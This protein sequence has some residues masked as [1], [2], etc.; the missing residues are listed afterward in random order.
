MPKLHAPVLLPAP[1][2]GGQ[3][4]GGAVFLGLFAVLAL[5][6]CFKYLALHTTV[7]GLGLPLSDCYSIHY[8][9]QWWLAFSPQARPLLPLVAQVYRLVPDQAAP[10]VLLAG[11]AFVLA[12]PVFWVAR[13]YGL[14]AALVAALYFPLWAI[15]LV[16]FHLTS[17]LVP[18][19]FAFLAS[20]NGERPGLA[21]YL[22][23]VPLL[24]GQDQCLTTVACGAYLLLGHGRRRS[25]LLLVAVGSLVFYA[26]GRWIIPFCSARSVPVWPQWFGPTGLVG[27]LTNPHAWFNLA[28]CF[29][30]LLFFPLFRPKLLL[31]AVPSL[32]MVFAAGPDGAWTTAVTAGAAG[33]L[34]YAFCE[35]LGPVRIL[36]RQTGI[37]PGRFMLTVLASVGLVH[38]LVAPSPLS[39][40]FWSGDDPAFGLAAY[41]PTARDAAILAELLRHVPNDVAVPVSAQNSLNWAALAERHHFA[42]F[43]QGVF[44]PQVARDLSRATWRDFLDF[45]RTGRNNTPAEAWQAQYVV[46]DL[47]RPWCLFARC[48]RCRDGACQDKALGRDFAAQ[49]QRARQDMDTVYDRDGFLILRRRPPAPAARPQPA[50][51]SQPT[52]APSAP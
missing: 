36:S 48:T 10:F 31:P 18:V 45:V 50:P 7:A 14:L 13:R 39:R 24:L 35:V 51:A 40:L 52:P 2:G 6:S 5:L 25:G 19:L 38:V 21:P 49:V 44:E 20:A 30:A 41:A 11:Q 26:E 23:L 8:A 34:L 12:L 9:S 42:T 4:L 22:G 15:A 47:T 1:S 27:L 33:V 16:D 28:V 3:G 29:G 37:G 46:L 43:P 17:L 32:V